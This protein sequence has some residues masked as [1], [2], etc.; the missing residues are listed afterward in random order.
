[1]KKCTDCGVEKPL[2]QFHNKT[3]SLDGKQ[4]RCKPCN[5]S[6]A[7]A[8][9]AANP[10]RHERYWRTRDADVDYVSDRK[11]KAKAKK[12]GITVERIKEMLAEANGIC[13]I[14]Q[15]PPAKYLCIDH[16][17]DSL[18]VRGVICERCNQSLGLLRDNKETLSRAILYLD[19][20]L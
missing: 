1:M 4:S 12:Y 7:K 14:C 20:E 8:W 18:A 11:L 2:D 10:E 17:H 6:K 16:C 19:G 15:R 13:K 9:Q 5:S 3:N